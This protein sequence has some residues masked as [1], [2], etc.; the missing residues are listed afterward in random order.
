MAGHHERAF[1]VWGVQ[2]EIVDQSFGEALYGKFRSAVGG[3]RY[4]RP[5]RGP[6]PVDAGSIDDMALVSLHQHRQE[7]T[8]AEINPSPADIEGP[9]PLLARVGEQTAATADAGVIEKQMNLFGSI[10]S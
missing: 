1:D 2:A 4:T 10:C 6:E 9:F 8:D 3:V 5:D 7:G